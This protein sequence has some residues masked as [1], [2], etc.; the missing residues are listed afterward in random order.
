MCES[1]STL[2]TFLRSAVLFVAVS[3]VAAPAL[4]QTLPPPTQTADLAGPRF[5]MTLLS[6]SLVDL[7]DTDFGIS[8][9]PVISQF[10]WQFERQFFTRNSG[11]TLVNEWVVLFGGLDQSVALPSVSWLVG[12]R[13][14]DGAEFGIGPN[15]TPAGMSL[16]FATGMTFKTGTMNVP[17]NVAVVP[18]KHGTRVTV[19]TGFSIRRR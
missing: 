9:R 14:R 6:Q 2:F 15:L 16:V 5:G 17:I 19:L 4:A 10:G 3:A 13:T 7:L 1:R 18:S 12:V 11:V 8:V